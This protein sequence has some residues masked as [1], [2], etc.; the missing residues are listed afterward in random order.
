MFSKWNRSG[1]ILAE[2]IVALNLFCIGSVFLIEQNRYLQAQEQQ[3]KEQLQQQ[4]AA[5]NA[6]FK[7]IEKSETG[8]TTNE[9]EL[10]Q[11]AVK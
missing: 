6:S 4:T 3:K 8:L 2:T 10:L 1:F 11:K 9:K 5:L 7:L